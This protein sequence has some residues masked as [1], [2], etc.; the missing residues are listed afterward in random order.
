M[1]DGRPAKWTGSRHESG[2]DFSSTTMTYRDLFQRQHQ[3]VP[4]VEGRT[5]P[6]GMGCEV[7]HPQTEKEPIV[8]PIASMPRGQNTEGRAQARQAVV[9]PVHHVDTAVLVYR[10]ELRGYHAIRVLVWFR[11][12]P[13]RSST[14]RE[15]ND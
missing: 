7:I 5:G 11:P 10:R 13:Y 12:G 15:F 2:H 8:R 6:Y 9:P 14:R 3:A 1:G 4:A